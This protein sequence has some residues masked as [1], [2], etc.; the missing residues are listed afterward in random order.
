MAPPIAVL[1]VDGTLVDTNYHHAIAWYRAFRQH[2][3]TLPVWRIHRHIGMGGDQLVAAVAGQ[4]VE[5]RQGDS[6]RAS[7]TALYA[8]LI[9]E[10]QPFADARRLMELLDGRG[11]RLVLA[12]S[13]KRDEV[14]HYLDLLDA[15]DLVEAWTTS[16]DVERTKPDPDLVVTAIDKVGGGEAV[17]V[18][19]STFDCQAAA[20]AGVPTLAILTGGFSEQE[21]REA[22]AAS[23][24]ES[25]SELCEH[26]DE[27]PLA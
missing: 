2:E 10:V 5:D 14:D 23:V 21:L 9:G 16:A 19:D 7:E 20:R 11:H 13:G 4:R 25:L 12:S 22:G 3:L 6:I 17:M 8:D 1:D 24:F 27:T 15:R 18:G 26:L